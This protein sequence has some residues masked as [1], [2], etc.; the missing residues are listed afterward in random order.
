MFDNEVY[1]KGQNG[2]IILTSSPDSCRLRLPDDN[3]GGGHGDV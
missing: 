2:N 3:D 1:N